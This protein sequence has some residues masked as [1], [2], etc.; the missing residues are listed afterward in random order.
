MAR[1]CVMGHEIPAGA[2]LLGCAE[3]DR[4]ERVAVVVWLR[5]QARVATKARR[6]ALSRAEGRREERADVVATG[7]D[8]PTACGHVQ[9]FVDDI[10]GGK[11]VGAR[12][13]GE[14]VSTICGTCKGKGVVQPGPK[15][16][17]CP[18]CSGRGKK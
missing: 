13:E 5:E 9:R 6:F 14:A 11:H 8:V 17:S 2:P 10:E 15:P 4:E 16:R 12:G 7:R 1:H 18:G 3:C